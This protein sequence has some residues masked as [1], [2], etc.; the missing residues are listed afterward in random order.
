M[1]GGAR[2]AGLR[3]SRRLAGLG[4]VRIDPVTKGQRR[5][6]VLEWWAGEDSLQERGRPAEQEEPWLTR[7]L[8]LKYG[9]NGAV[10][11]PRSE[12]TTEMTLKRVG[13]DP[14]T[15]VGTLYF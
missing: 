14:H 4:R 10:C 9:R 1:R 12:F 2:P 3:R 5:V 13:T 7:Q 6:L 11:H 8:E 15:L